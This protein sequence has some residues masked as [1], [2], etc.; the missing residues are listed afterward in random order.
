VVQK[1]LQT[2]VHIHQTKQLFISEGLYLQSHCRH[3]PKRQYEYCSILYFT[4]R[5]PKWSQH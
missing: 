5:S 4:P 1:A 2:S 3:K